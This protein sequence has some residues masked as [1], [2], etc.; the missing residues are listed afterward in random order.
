V[1]KYTIL[2]GSLWIPVTWK[3]QE[4]TDNINTDLRKLVLTVED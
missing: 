1:K 2:L 3:T 4:E